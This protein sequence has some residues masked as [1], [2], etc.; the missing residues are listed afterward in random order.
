VAGKRGARLVEGFEDGSAV[1][2]DRDALGGERAVPVGR[3][4]RAV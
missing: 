1:V 3:A 2:L 4:E